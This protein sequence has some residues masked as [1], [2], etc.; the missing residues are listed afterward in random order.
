MTDCSQVLEECFKKYTI[1]EVFL[2]FNG[3]KDCTVLLDMTLQELQTI[4]KAKSDIKLLKFYYIQPP[5]PFPELEQ[6]IRE[7]EIKYGLNMIIVPGNIKDAL[8][9]IVQDDNSLK[10]CLMGNRK[11]DPYSEHLQFFEVST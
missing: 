1:S 3:G 10:A 6:F 11:T 2:S 4:L 5:N 9:K 7:I 8:G